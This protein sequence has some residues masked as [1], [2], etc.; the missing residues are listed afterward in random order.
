MSEDNQKNSTTG[1]HSPEGQECEQPSLSRRKLLA[2]S[3]SIPI[4][5]TLA[6]RPVLGAQNCT[7]S[8]FMSGNLSHPDAYGSCGGKSPGY[9][10]ASQHIGSWPAPYMP[11]LTSET[12][13]IIGNEMP[14][15]YVGQNYTLFVDAFGVDDYPGLSMMDV[16]RIEPGGVAFHALAAL[17]NAASGQY[18]D[19]RL[20]ITLVKQIYQQYSYNGYYNGGG[21]VM[22]E[23]TIKDFFNNTYH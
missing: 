21:L 11:G 14:A 3:I 1:T 13:N 4:I 22:D 19:P 5:S 2:G 16:L 20:T 10:K 8:G 6:S 12:Y 9:W 23:D 15:N 17:L 7:P 18:T